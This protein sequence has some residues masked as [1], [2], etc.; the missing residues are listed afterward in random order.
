MACIDGALFTPIS[1]SEIMVYSTQQ[2]VRLEKW[3]AQGFIPSAKLYQKVPEER[4]EEFEPKTW[5]KLA[6]E[7]VFNISNESKMALVELAYCFGVFDKEH[8]E[9]RGKMKDMADVTEEERRSGQVFDFQKRVQAILD[10]VHEGKLNDENLHMMFDGTNMKF[11]PAFYR[12]FIDNRD[13]ILA[14][15]DVMWKIPYIQKAMPRIMEKFR[16]NIPTVEQCERYFSA[17]TLEKIEEGNEKLAELCLLAGV[18][19]DTFE[20]YQELYHQQ[21]QRDK[22]STI[23]QLQGKNYEILSLTDPETL[24]IGEGGFSRCCQ[25]LDGAGSECMKH[26]ATSQNG[27][28]VVLRDDEGRFIA[29]S[30]MW[31]NGNVVCFDSIEANAIEKNTTAEQNEYVDLIR[32]TYRKM[33][34]DII[35]KTEEEVNRFKEEK[36]E[37]IAKEDISEERRRQKLEQLEEV[38]E[39]SRVKRVTVGRGYW[40]ISEKIVEDF[41]DKEVDTS[42]GRVTPREHVSYIADSNVQY[43]LAEVE[44]VKE[45]GIK[46]DSATVAV[47]YRDVRRVKIE[48]GEDIQNDTIYKIKQIES[49]A[50]KN[51]MQEMGSASS[52]YDIANIYETSPKNLRI[53]HGED[54]YYI[55]GNEEDS[56]HVYDLAR[57]KSRFEDEK[58]KGS[59]EMGKALDKIM[60]EAV[61]AGKTVEAELREDTSYILMLEL[62][63]AG[64]IEQ[65]G[66][67]ETFEY[68]NP[69]DSESVSEEQQMEILSRKNEIR[70]KEGAEETT[71]MHHVSFIPTEKYKR[72]LER[73]YRKGGERE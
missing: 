25:S 23:P 60:L 62:K 33:A 73:R 15:I 52:I 49:E 43:V 66:D 9:V 65:V 39:G 36:Q 70:E 19:Q 26:S 50:H 3:F 56:I 5:F 6:R 2:T 30:W 17:I 67:D 57:G 55:Y 58:I 32:S 18:P 14:N 20:G 47:K 22:E 46:T 13:D 10:M 8:A 4:I 61:E 24:V 45:S 16:G 11:D 21:K 69:W 35:A 38:C 64:L 44:D 7:P 37:E 59:S 41:S 72:I 31:R 48:K 71:T 51:Q 27:R 68:G 63:E 42:S 53:I 40:P 54:W 29:Q 12:F 28:L 34:K 1:E